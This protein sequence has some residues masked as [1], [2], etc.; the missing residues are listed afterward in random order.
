MQS[1]RLINLNYLNPIHEICREK[2]NDITTAQICCLAVR[3]IRASVINPR[4]LKKIEVHE[5]IIP[6]KLFVRFHHQ[7]ISLSRNVIAQVRTDMRSAQGGCFSESLR[8]VC[9]ASRHEK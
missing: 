7:E 4:D 3:H 6:Y 2:E 9:L 8:T 5:V 1:K